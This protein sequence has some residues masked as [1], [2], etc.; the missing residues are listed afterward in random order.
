VKRHE[1][2][3]IIRAA[4]AIT[5]RKEIVVVGS[6]AILGQ[7]PEAD[8]VLAESLEADVFT[9]ASPDDGELIDGSI[10][11][12]SFF[13]QTFGYYAHGVDLETSTLPRGWRERLVAVQNENTDGAVGL[14]LEVHDL[15]VSKLVAGREKDLNFLREVLQR[16]YADPELVR[17]RLRD[18]ALSTDRLELCMHRLNRLLK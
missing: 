1:L 2:E 18:C 5:T 10:G 14:C 4:S 16:K 7:F 8:G 15:F 11:E 12:R 9:F 13:H 6:Q 3:H 17:Q